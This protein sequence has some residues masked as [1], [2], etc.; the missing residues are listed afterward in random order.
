MMLMESRLTSDFAARSRTL[1]HSVVIA[2]LLAHR[3]AAQPPS[4]NPQQRQADEARCRSLQ[5]R[6]MVDADHKGVRE[7]LDASA[8]CPQAGLPILVARW[9]RPPAD[10]TLLNTLVGASARYND[11]RLLDAALA[12]VA[13]RS[14]SRDA[15]LAGVS[16]A[17]FMVDPSEGILEFGKLTTM[18][19]KP[20][21]SIGSR[22][23]GITQKID[24]EQP[25]SSRARQQLVDAYE[26]MRVRPGE[27]QYFVLV[28]TQLIRSLNR[29]PPR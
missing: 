15:R 22:F 27:D 2:L 20:Y 5:A 3:I 9:R 26:A 4:S 21:V 13:D 28:F 16:A 10:S 23:S 6:V 19:G 12:I 29:P 25:L 14:K 1:V 18:A 8:L 24:G 11:Q 7:A 17:H